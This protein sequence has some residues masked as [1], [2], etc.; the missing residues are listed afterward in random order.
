MVFCSIM[1]PHGGEI[2][3]SPARSP[4]LLHGSSA[5]RTNSCTW[6]ISMRSGTGDLHRN[7]WSVCGGSCS[8]KNL[9][10]LSLAQERPI[11]SAST[12]MKLFHTRDS[13][14]KNIYGSI[15]NISAPLK[16]K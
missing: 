7:T 15:Q 13:T 1:N 14:Q 11:R 10:I 2:P 6:E 16:L 3:L 12:C 9:M 5:E 4:V 8:R